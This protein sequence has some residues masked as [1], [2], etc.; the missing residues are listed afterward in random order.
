MSSVSSSSCLS[1]SFMSYSLL[2]VSLSRTSCLVGC[3]LIGF[4]G[5]AGCLGM[6]LMKSLS[7]ASHFVP[8]SAVVSQVVSLVRSLSSVLDLVGCK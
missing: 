2:V 6:L 4:V 3:W 5:R 7:I 8:S 1:S